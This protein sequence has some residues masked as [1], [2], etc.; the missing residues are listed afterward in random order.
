MLALALLVYAGLASVFIVGCFKLATR[1]S[2]KA[3]EREARR[4]KRLAKLEGWE[5]H[6]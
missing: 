1:T 6:D 4:A 2:Q 3:A 5:N